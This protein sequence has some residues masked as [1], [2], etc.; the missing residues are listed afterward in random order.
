MALIPAT[1][2]TGF[3]RSRTTT[4]LTRT[5]TEAPVQ[6]IAVTENEFREENI[7]SDLPLTQST[8]QL[9]QTCTGSL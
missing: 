2:L 3:L 1:I 6:Q 4:L 8:D 5:L 9:L 7:D